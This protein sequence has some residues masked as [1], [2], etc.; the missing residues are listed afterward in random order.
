[1]PD[2]TRTASFA[3]DAPGNP[4]HDGTRALG[5][6]GPRLGEDAGRLADDLGLLAAEARRFLAHRLERSPYG[7]LAAAAGT[8]YVLGGGVPPWLVRAGLAVGARAVTS[9]IFREVL[10]PDPPAR[11]PEPDPDAGGDTPPV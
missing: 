9:V 2:P 7:T 10:A 1:M 11:T 5:D 3:G 4:N 6:R 8:G